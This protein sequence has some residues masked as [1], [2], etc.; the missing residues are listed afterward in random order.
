MTT[1][2]IN[3]VAIRTQAIG[4][5][6]VTNMGHVSRELSEGSHTHTGC[7]QIP[8]SASGVL[9][10]RKIPLSSFIPANLHSGDTPRVQSLLVL[11]PLK[12]IEASTMRSPSRLAEVLLH[13]PRKANPSHDL[14]MLHTI[15]GHHPGT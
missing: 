2:R 4:L 13:T 12:K 10:V 5:S 15:T 3:Q 9:P 7:M 1:G 8:A 11:F 14:F 6:L